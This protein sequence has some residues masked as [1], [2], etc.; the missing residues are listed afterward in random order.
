MLSQSQL[1]RSMLVQRSKRAWETVIVAMKIQNRKRK[2]DR[3]SNR[4]RIVCNGKLRSK[5]KATSICKGWVG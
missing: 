2:K 4:G 3:R 1:Q 5:R